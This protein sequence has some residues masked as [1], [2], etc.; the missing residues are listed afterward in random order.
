MGN[1]KRAVQLTVDGDAKVVNDYDA[2][3]ALTRQHVQSLLEAN[4]AVGVVE[5]LLHVRQQ[6]FL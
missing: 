5:G 6:A 3:D 1:A 2:L 4:Y